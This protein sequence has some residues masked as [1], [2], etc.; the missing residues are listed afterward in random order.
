LL[1]ITATTFQKTVLFACKS[2]KVKEALIFYG[3][4]FD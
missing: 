3:D 4:E 2:S 1:Q